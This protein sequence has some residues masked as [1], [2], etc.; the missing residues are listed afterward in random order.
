MNQDLKNKLKNK[1]K[2]KPVYDASGTERNN[3]GFV[4][5]TI[6][7]I[8][9]I[10]CIGTLLMFNNKQVQRLIGE[11]INVNSQDNSSETLKT[12]TLLTEKTLNV[13]AEH[14]NGTIGRLNNISFNAENTVIEIAVT[15]GSRHT[16]HLNLYGKGIILLDD[17]GNKYNLKP[18]FNNPYLQIESGTTFTGELVFQG[19][20]TTKANNLSL[21]TNNQI[22]S[23]QILTR[24]PK[25]E[26]NIP[27]T[28][29]D[30][31]IEEEGVEGGRGGRGG[32]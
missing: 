23:D 8:L 2:D 6:S 7:A 24:R 17:L 31:L 11:N 1:L 22:G 26:F 3:S 27:I 10:V 4:L 9:L 12:D 21:I 19:G 14:S 25:M 15:N 18:P 28:Q 30:K 29:E 32:E 13:R 16:I 5:G 20:I